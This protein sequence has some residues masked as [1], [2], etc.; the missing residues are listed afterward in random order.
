MSSPLYRLL[1]TLANL[2]MRLPRPVRK[3]MRHFWISVAHLGVPLNMHLYPLSLAP[4]DAPRRFLDR[5]SWPCRDP[6]PREVVPEAEVRV[7]LHLHYHELWPEF[8]AILK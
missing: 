7:V 2:Y 5:T 4:G 3:T 1:Y 8:E 6:R